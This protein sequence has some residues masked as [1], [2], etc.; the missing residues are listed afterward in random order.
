M[1]LPLLKI[2][3]H[4]ISKKSWS[5]DTKLVVWA[6]MCVAFFGSFRM[7]ELLSKSSGSF[8]P[9]DTLLWE[10]IRFLKDGSIQILN[11][12]PKNRLKSEDVIDLFPFPGNCCPVTTLC[13]L[14]AA[15]PLEDK[16]PVF[17]FKSG[18][19]LTQLSL[20]TIIVDCLS[21]HFGVKAKDYSGH[22]FRAGL[23]SALS[24]CQSLSTE[25]AIKKWGRWK[26]SSFQKYTRLNHSAKKEVFSLFSQA[27]Q[28]K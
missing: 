19:F 17:K 6:A 10:N 20:N 2:L 23:P 7:G 24:S 3:G 27:L 1:T 26:S 22:S 13:A 28:K 18:K 4:E 14:K 21:P 25:A 9:S 16:I 11:K 15:R 5:A 12:I 8:N